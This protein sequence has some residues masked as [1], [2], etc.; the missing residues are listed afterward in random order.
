MLKKITVIYYYRSIYQKC[1]YRQII[2]YLQGKPICIFRRGRYFLMG[3]K[4]YSGR[5]MFM[6][7]ALIGTIKRPGGIETNKLSGKGHFAQI[8]NKVDLLA[9]QTQF[10]SQVL[11]VKGDSMF[12]DR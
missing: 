2:D 8:G 12:R 11:P 6:E 1:K 10:L 4:I 9:N 7:R 3:Q 5:N